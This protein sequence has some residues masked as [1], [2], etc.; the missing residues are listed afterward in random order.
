[1][2]LKLCL[3]YH[4]ASFSGWQIQV[5]QKTVQ[6]ELERSL[7]VYLQS[8]AKQQGL[9]SPTIPSITGSGRT[10]AGVH[11]KNQIASFVWPAEI[12][13]DTFRMRQSLNGISDR[14]LY[15]KSIEGVGDFFD[16]KSSPHQKCYAYKII[17]AKASSPLLGDRALCIPQKLDFYAMLRASKFIKGEQD[18]KSFQAADCAAKTT[19]RTIHASELVLESDGSITYYIVGKGFLKQMVRTI[20]GTLIEIGMGK[21]SPESMKEIIKAKD[22][23][24]AGPVAEAK[25]LCLEWVKYE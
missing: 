12:P 9:E 2:K 8:L 14:G 23:L 7:A 20:V 1:M 10:D 24:F 4:G 13:L 5:S 11:A 15:I 6:G 19:I 3:E 25:G 22:R 18:F 17:S 21:R 16:A